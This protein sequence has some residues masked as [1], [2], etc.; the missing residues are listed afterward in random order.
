V[1]LKVW[2]DGSRV[3]FKYSSENPDSV[4]SFLAAL[5]THGVSL[6]R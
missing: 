3:E 2:V 4:N 5:K 1:N 6:G